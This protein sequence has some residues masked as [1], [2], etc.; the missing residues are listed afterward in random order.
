MTLRRSSS[1]T[2][3]APRPTGGIGSYRCSR[4]RTASSGSTCSGTAVRQI[5]RRRVRDRV[6]GAPGRSA[7]DR[8]GV[9][10]AFVVGHS[11]GGYVATALAEQ[12]GDL[13]TAIAFI[14]TGPRMDAFISDGL[15]GKLIDVPVLG[16]LLWRLRTDGIIRRG[17]S[18]AFGPRIPDPAATGRRHPRHDVS[19]AHRD[20]PCLRRP[21]QPACAPGSAGTSAQAASRDLR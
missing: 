3:S 6:T 19:R 17:L 7:L 13:V 8:L 10:H 20:L 16:Q 14:D 18:T 4:A 21:S 12:R 9:E 15:V 1:S 2:G 11:T 5:G